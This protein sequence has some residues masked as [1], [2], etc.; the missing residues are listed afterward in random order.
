MYSTQ[1]GFGNAAGQAFNTPSPQQQMQQPPQQQP[2]QQQQMQQPVSH[3][4]PGS[5]PGQQIM[6]GPPFSMA[7]GPGPYGAV[8]GGPNMMANPGP[9][10]IMQNPAMPHMAAN[11]QR[12]HHLN[13][14]PGTPIGLSTPQA[15]NFPNGSGH[16][17][18]GLISNGVGA[19]GQAVGM[20]APLS[21]GTESR[22]KELFTV[23]L[24][25]NQELL[26][27]SVQ[28]RNTQIALKKEHTAEAG[29]DEPS[30]T[31]SSEPGSEEEKLVRAD[32][33]QCMK[34]I[35]SNLSYLASLADR[36]VT[37]NA[38]KGPGFLMA[39]ALSLGFRLRP[40][41]S[42]APDAIGMT[43]V[44]INSDREDRLRYI[45]EL[46]A[47]LQSFYPGVDY[48]KEPAFGPQ[49]SGAHGAPGGAG[50]PGPNPAAMAAFNNRAMSQGVH[51]A[52]PVS[53][54]HRTP[55]MGMM[56]GP[57]GPPQGIPMA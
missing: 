51:Q 29:V 37:A 9:A 56:A 6:Y 19:H 2:L 49:S 54:P 46:Y 4:P 15:G 25:I 53:Q 34:R 8:A 16:G 48:T 26:Y 13:N 24:S 3:M 11:G 22:E 40:Q 20:G 21:P 27:E 39:P 17:V 30:V 47:K 52:S 45:K 42:S 33:I 10:G 12:Q 31:E 14:M 5:M 43:D 23:L 57:P 41:P 18:G 28:L 44:D 32:Y 1:Y 55:Q 35:Q 7:A 50:V 38:A 36:K